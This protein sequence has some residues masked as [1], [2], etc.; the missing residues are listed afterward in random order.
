M[1]QIKYTG[2]GKKVAVIGKLNAEQAIVQEIFVSAGQEIPSGENFVVKSLHD[3]PAIS[4]KEND[5]KKQEERY[6]RETKRLKDDLES[7]SRRLGIAKEKA[8]S[9]ADA[10]M[11]FAN[12]AEAPQLDILKK[13]LSGEITHLYKAGYSP[14]IFEWADDL[15][16]FDT[17]NDSW[18]R[19]VKVD[20][21]KL[22]SLFGYSDGNLAYRLHTYRDGSGG[23]AEILPATSYEQALGWAQADFNKQCAEYLA[24]TNRGLSLETWKKIEGIVTP[25]E[26]VEKYEAEKTKSKRE[27]IE[28]LRVELEKLES[29]L[30]APPTE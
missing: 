27:R 7:Q 30:P 15:K 24:G 21:M 29:E 23:S 2:D 17:D 8:K 10:L 3:A 18:N 26:V 11:A 13:F 20:G 12:K 22:V 9:H 28:K 14:E 5:L 1:T 25:P 6:E 4:W 19:R 16:S